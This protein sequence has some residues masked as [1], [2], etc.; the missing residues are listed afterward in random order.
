MTFT[1]PAALHQLLEAPDERA[2][3][4]AWAAFLH[5]YSALILHVARSRNRDHDA[6]MNCY[7]FVLDQLQRNGHARLTRYIS[8][9]RGKFTTWL[10]VVV[11][12]LCVD[13]HRQRY[14][15]PQ[16]GDDDEYVQRRMLT[17]LVSDAVALENVAAD[18][19][20]DAALLEAESLALLGD[21][22]ERLTPSDRL[23]LRMRFEDDM[24]VPEIARL[25]GAASPFAMYRRLQHTLGLL[26]RALERAGVERAS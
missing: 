2:R 7:A 14:G 3:D 17:D 16:S 19:T 6:V 4:T 18:D 22:L 15:R 9:G 11:R 26:R 25:F 1:P 23:I 8:D 24:S 20:A 13:Y 5:E 12:R 21:A 10:L